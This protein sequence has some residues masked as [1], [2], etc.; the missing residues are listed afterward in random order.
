VVQ[1]ADAQLFAEQPPVMQPP[2]AQPP[3]PPQQVRPPGPPSPPNWRRALFVGGIGGAIVAIALIAVLVSQAH[4][5]NRRT[6]VTVATIQV[7]VTTTPAGASIRIAPE[8]SGA[9]PAGAEAAETKCTSN[10]K[11][12]LAPGSY[13]VTAFLDGFQPAT[14]TL[15]VATGQ[16]AVVDLTLMPQAQSVRILTDLDQGKVAF[17]DQPPVD[18]QEGQLVLDDVKPGVH[19]VKLTSR[20]STASFSFEIADAKLPTV[21]GSVSARNL[22]A[23]LVS[24]FGTQAHVVTNSGPLKLALNGQP[25]GDAGPEG[26]DLKDFQ[27]GVDEIVVGEGK[28]QRNVK[29][30]FGPAPMLTAFLK[31]DVNAGTLIVSTGEDDVHVF[32]N[33][34]EYRQRTK[35]GQ[36]RIQ[37][38]GD[39]SVR[40]A[41]DGFQ[42]EPV[43]TAEVKKGSEVRLEF[44]LKAAPQLGAFLIRGGTA[45]AEVFLDQKSVGTV[46]A[47]GGF[48][49]NTVPPGDHV[50]EIRRDQYAPKRFQRTIKAGQIVIFTGADAVLAISNG[51]IRLAR[52]PAA[53]AVTYHRADE[54]ETHDLRGNQV[55]LPPGV[56]VFSAKAPGFVDHTE[57]VQ[58]AGGETRTLE[59]NLTRERAAPAPVVTA[60]IGDFEDPS[61]WKKDGELWIHRG[62]GFIPF[63]LTPKGVFAFTV[64]LLK[65]GNVFRGG[66][67]R[68]AIQYVDAKNYLLFELD[69]KN[70]WAEVVENGKRLERERTQHDLDKQKAFTIEIDIAP[71]R[72]IHRVREGD[73]WTVLDSFSEPGRN[74][75]QGKFGFLIQGNDEIGIS[76]FKFTPK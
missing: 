12:D 24:S 16:P 30:S 2:V 37:T 20:N 19:T 66:R 57:R 70:F 27:A 26:V 56:Y 60:G 48:T 45:G 32:V 40:V 51:T 76:D 15:T 41:K 5:R 62:G 7:D 58:L 39:V 65:G 52:T 54:A 34:K 18:L 23:V 75:T 21:T 49:D 14:S 13:Q 47:D 46:S 38:L 17:D 22:A 6:G 9:S 33:S 53:A 25:Q 4:K 68:W 55:E 29:E 28:D 69:K 67:I 71:D 50:I 36:V 8:Q 31:S 63:K 42:E 11:V 44:K 73:E 64:E 61:A 1:A 43:Q 10:C 59:I 74:F 35:R 72:L 3:K